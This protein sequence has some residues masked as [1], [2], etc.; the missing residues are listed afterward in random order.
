MRG[1]NFTQ[2][3]RDAIRILL[4]HEFSIRKIAAIM[5][6]GKSGIQTQIKRMEADGSIS[7]GIMDLG[8]V[9][10]DNI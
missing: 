3:E 2:A 7:Q 10:E 4:S 8:Q 6:R 5:G 9:D 1:K